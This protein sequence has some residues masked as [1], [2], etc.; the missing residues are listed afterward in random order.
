MP[1]FFAGSTGTPCPNRADGE[2]F[3][4]GGLT[5]KCFPV[6]LG[7]RMCPRGR[8]VHGGTFGKF[9][10]F[11]WK[12]AP[13]AVIFWPFRKNSRT[14]AVFATIPAQRDC[15]SWTATGGRMKD[16]HKKAEDDRG[17][18]VAGGENPCL[19]GLYESQ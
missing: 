11:R 10:R 15:S 6:A 8:G 4:E 7:K 19:T 14:A 16:T 17:V 1:T 9:H 2:T 12:C 5:A 13:V 3:S 18:A